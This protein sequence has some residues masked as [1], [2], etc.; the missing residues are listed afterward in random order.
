MKTIK[1]TLFLLILLFSGKAQAQMAAAK[2]FSPKVAVEV[3]LNAPM[4]KVWEYLQDRDV[5]KK[6]TGARTFEIQGMYEDSPV[7]VV[8]KDGT[9]RKQHISAIIEPRHMVCF[10]VT[11][12]DYLK[13]TWGYNFDVK[14]KNDRQCIVSMK[15]F[16]GEAPVPDALKKNMQKE[17]EHMKKFLEKEFK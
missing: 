2:T 14:A 9:S 16:N 12:S 10:F 13:N 3:T 8:G 17:F 7:K 1:V 5:Y 6:M 15:V 11:Q 4:E